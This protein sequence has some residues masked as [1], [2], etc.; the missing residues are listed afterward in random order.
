MDHQS[1]MAHFREYV[2]KGETN[3]EKPD[4]LE[5]RVYSSFEKSRDLFCPAHHTDLKRRAIR[6]A[7]IIKLQKFVASDKWILNFKRKHDI[8]SRKITKARKFWII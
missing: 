5:N 2:E 6:E 8:C 1:Y 7:K 3:K 4:S